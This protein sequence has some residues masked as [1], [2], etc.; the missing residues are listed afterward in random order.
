MEVNRRYLFGG[1]TALPVSKKGREPKEKDEPI[2]TFLGR[3]KLIK[4]LINVT[5]KLDGV[6]FIGDGSLGRWVEE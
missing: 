4:T 6:E 1:Q 3:I 2:D 5:I